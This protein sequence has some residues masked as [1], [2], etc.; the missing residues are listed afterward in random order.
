MVASVPATAILNWLPNPEATVGGG[1]MIVGAMIAG[2]FAITRSVDPG[3][4]GL[5]AGLLGGVVAALAFVFTQAVTV[6]WSVSRLAFF[7]IAVGFVLCVAPIFGSIS[8]QVGG[9]I[10]G[11]VAAE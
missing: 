9:R 10:A 7:G 6:T 11:A 4:A 3:A 2:A 8:G 5:R 1:V